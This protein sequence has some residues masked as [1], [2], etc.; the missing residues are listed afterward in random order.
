MRKDSIPADVRVGMPWT[1]EKERLKGV[2]YSRISFH[3]V[4][5]DENCVGERRKC[6]HN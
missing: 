1:L 2:G 4:R 6:Q 3:F 5:H